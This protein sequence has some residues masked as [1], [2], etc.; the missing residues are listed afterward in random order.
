M[1]CSAC[2]GHSPCRGSTTDGRGNRCRNRRKS[3]AWDKSR[4]AL[5]E[6][7]IDIHPLAATRTRQ[8]PFA[9]PVDSLALPIVNGNLRFAGAEEVTR[10]RMPDRRPVLLPSQRHFHQART[11][12]HET[13]LSR[14][15][16]T[17]TQHLD[18]S[19]HCIQCQ[20]AKSRISKIFAL[21]GSPVV[22]AICRYEN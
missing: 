18:S 22:L 9:I 8:H 16:I 4:R 17:L 12:R 13:P 15:P 3:F 6:P 19:I 11:A 21:A 1:G 7:P 14:E 2:R 20:Q 5:Q 10:S